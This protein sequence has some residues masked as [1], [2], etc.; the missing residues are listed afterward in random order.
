VNEKEENLKRIVNSKQ[1]TG[2]GAAAQIKTI[3]VKALT[4]NKGKQAQE[5]VAMSVGL[6][7]R[8]S[9]PLR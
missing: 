6:R 4:A 7:M 1:S 9:S 8:L 5:R 3:R 2:A